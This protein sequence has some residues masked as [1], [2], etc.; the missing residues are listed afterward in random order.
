MNKTATLFLIICYIS[1]SL[2]AQ[3]PNLNIIFIL[4]DDQRWDA[5]GYAGNNIIQT[6]EMDKLAK[7]GI[8]FENAFVTTPICAASRA[9]IMTG[10]YERAHRY[11]F[12]QPPLKKEYIENSY[13]SVLKNAGYY[14][15]FL[16]KF[17][18]N[19]EN[20]LDTVL[21][22]F[23]KP[24][25]QNSY[26]NLPDGSPAKEHLTD[27]IG[28]N[29]IE[30]IKN[31]PGDRP[32]CLSISFHAPHAVDP[33]PEQYV[34]PKVLDT[35]YSDVTIP[36]PLMGDP[37][38]FDKLPEPV[39]EGFNRSRWKWR[40]DTPDKYQQMVKGYYRMITGI[41]RTI[42][43]IRAVLDQEGLSKNTVI[44]L[45]GDNGYFLG[46][47]QL[48]GKWLMYEPS[49]RVPLIIYNPAGIGSK[50]IQDM[51][52]NVDVTPT[53]LDFANAV[54]PGT[55]QG[56][57]LK[58]YTSGDIAPV[59][60]RDFFLCEH[61]WDFEPIPASEGVRTGNYKYFRYIDDPSVEELYHIENDSN[62]EFNLVDDQEFRQI[63]QQLRDKCNELIKRMSN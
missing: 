11:T 29:A 44:I 16:G 7:E 12:G 43:K 61:L 51:V 24:E 27:R 54:V 1:G 38:N 28:N 6:P 30:F 23:Y 15:G 35:L 55:Y 32:F 21:F 8:Y 19:F 33:A 46:E 10:L 2:V 14:N 4:T 45:M 49:L 40:F 31:A 5:L 58:N 53:I 18:V 56:M 39:K 13:F 62:E 57:S 42:G 50:T 20:H 34:W 63:L 52:L 17:G 26:Y 3:D 9:S 22:D 25:N 59:G 36:G 47:R 37:Q 41:D 60:K 48:A